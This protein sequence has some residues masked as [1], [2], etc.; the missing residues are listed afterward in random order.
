MVH[1]KVSQL[2]IVR[3]AA[4]DRLPPPAVDNQTPLRTISLPRA[5]ILESIQDRQPPLRTISLQS[6][7]I[8]ESISDSKVNK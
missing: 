3:D 1:Q 6:A 8:L 4:A 5:A 7:A 2:C